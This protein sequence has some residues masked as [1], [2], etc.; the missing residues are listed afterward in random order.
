MSLDTY[1]EA[2]ETRFDRQTD[3]APSDLTGSA[4]STGLPRNARYGYADVRDT[5]K[6]MDFKKINND[7]ILELLLH[8]HR[9]RVGSRQNV[10][11]SNNRKKEAG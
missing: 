6:R 2:N 4:T 1:S 11:G 9:S 7:L 10:P 8:I 3:H 5:I